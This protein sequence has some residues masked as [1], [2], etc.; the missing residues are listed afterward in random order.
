MVAGKSKGAILTMTSMR[1]IVRCN[2]AYGDS[3]TG[4]STCIILPASFDQELR[5]LVHSSLVV[6]IKALTSFSDK[7]FRSVIGPTT[8]DITVLLVRLT[9]SSTLEP[10]DGQEACHGQACFISMWRP[11]VRADSCGAVVYILMV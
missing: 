2:T 11:E 10:C 6:L 7:G 3:R 4:N 5:Q 1:R 8:F 9:A